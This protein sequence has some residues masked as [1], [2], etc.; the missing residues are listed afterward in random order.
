M[1]ILT[2]LSSPG[3]E[4]ACLNG[5]NLTLKSEAVQLEHQYIQAHQIMGKEVLIVV[6]KSGG[7]VL[8]GGAAT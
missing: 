7:A 2:L 3:C 8:S 4:K 6:L 5:S 1:I